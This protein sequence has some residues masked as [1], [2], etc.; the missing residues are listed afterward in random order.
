MPRRRST[1]CEAARVAAPDVHVALA[2]H[3]S[4]VLEAPG[5]VLRPWH[6]RDL[7]TMVELFDDPQVAFFTPLPSP[8]T[9]ADAEDR[10]ARARQADRLLLAITTDGDRALGEILLFPTGELG[11]TIGARH[12][13]KG[14]AARALVL[15]RDYAHDVVGL[16]VLRLRIEPGNAASAGTARRA[17]FRLASSPAEAAEDKGRSFTVAVWEHARDQ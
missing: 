15:L 12:R 8:F 1:A 2:N 10:L 6:E 9:R 11:Y 7:D 3:A 5:L 14:L 17:G 16:A 4:L 13:G